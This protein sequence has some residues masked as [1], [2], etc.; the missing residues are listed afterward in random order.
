ME[1]PTLPCGP[2]AWPPQESRAE[3][4]TVAASRQ[5]NTENKPGPGTGVTLGPLSERGRAEGVAYNLLGW[6]FPLHVNIRF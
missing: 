3:I 2:A 6:L 1:M 4:R 5:V